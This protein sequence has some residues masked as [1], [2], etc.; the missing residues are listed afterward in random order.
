MGS[1]HIYG[2]IQP[3]YNFVIITFNWR[4][5]SSLTNINNLLGL[6]MS[7]ISPNRKFGVTFIAQ[8]ASNLQI[9]PLM[10]KHTWL[11]L[12]TPLLLIHLNLLAQKPLDSLDIKMDTIFKKLN[13][14]N[15]PGCAV[16]VVQNGTV[17]FKKGYGMANLE[18][19]LPITPSS[20][21][22]I[23]SLSKQFC[24]LAIST[25]IQQGKLNIDDDVHKYLPEVPDFGKKITLKNLLHHT[26]GLRDWPEALFYAGWNYDEEASMDDILRMVKHQEELD[27]DPGAEYQY[28]N[29]GYNLL[30]EII[31]KVSGKTFRKYI[32]STIFKPLGMNA[33]QF[34]DDKGTI[35]PNLAYS[36]DNDGKKF[37]KIPNVLTALGSSSLY[38]SADDLCK[39]VIN[40]QAQLDAKNPVY[41]RMLEE[42]KLNNGTVNHYGFGMSNGKYR[43]LRGT[44]HTGGWAA[45]NTI[46]QNYPD[47]KLSI[48]ILCNANDQDTYGKYPKAIA[49]ILLKDKFIADKKVEADKTPA[50]KVDTML[51]K[52]YAGQYK[53][54]SG[55][56]TITIKNSMLMFQYI[57][58]D[59]FPTKALSDSSFQVI[60]AGLP[61]TFSKPAKGLSASFTFRD[62][63]GKRFVPFVPTPA[64]LARYSGTYYSHEL[65]TEYK[66]YVENGKLMLHHFRHG[67]IAL[68]TDF[69]DEFTCDWGT[70]RFFRDAKNKILGYK[71]S[72]G[73]VRNI[74]FDKQS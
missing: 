21:F 74:R 32:D 60:V 63:V 14:N 64:E 3:D 45:Y 38:T 69:K 40:L 53:W 26:S 31:E 52:E 50:V 57:G 71:I 28:S 12:L 58:E 61:V 5:K 43:G 59:A 62:V 20:V 51:L 55:E 46:I 42:S 33:S 70:I 47:E 72:G 30:A 44:N 34:L 41:L 15:G 25:M 37:V 22:D 7:P 27:F 11:F 2:C 1:L 8:T 24:G 36:Y 29:T 67:D 23:A 73:R 6:K 56:V 13:R 39:W 16:A 10:M 49:D 9:Y 35:V 4:N 19:N 48:I 18:Y 17:V 68:T 66:V 54:K 65:E